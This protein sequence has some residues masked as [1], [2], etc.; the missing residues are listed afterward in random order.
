MAVDNAV[1]GGKQ[2]H[3]CVV[4][5]SFCFYD[6]RGMDRNWNPEWKLNTRITPDGRS[7]SAEVTLPFASLGSVP[8][9]G[10]FWRLVLDRNT[11]PQSSGL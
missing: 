9:T 7:W 2:K 6:A 8:E 1:I 4:I 10:S 3:Y 11:K 5:M